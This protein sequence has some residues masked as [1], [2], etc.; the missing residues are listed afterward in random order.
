MKTM[1]KII[2]GT[3]L[4]AL[5][6]S[7]KP[8]QSV[9]STKIDDKSQVAIKGDWQITKVSFV[10]DQ[11]MKVTSF[12]V[13]DSK[14]FEGS[15]WR[16]I[17]MSNKGTMVLAKKDCPEYSSPITWFVNKEGQFVLKI[18]DN[19]K[20]KTVTNGYVLRIAN[21]TSNSFQLVDKVMIGKNAADVVYQFEKLK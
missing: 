3:I 12:D 9:T 16:F 11:V 17:S 18:L 19:A 10:G 2:L 13:A 8:S 4:A 1:R 15:V 14:C 7:C 21:Q 20:A 5:F 6:I